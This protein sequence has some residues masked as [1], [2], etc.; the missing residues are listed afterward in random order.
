MRILLIEDEARISRFVSKGLRENSFAV[1]V[2]AS[3][4]TALYQVSINDYDLIILDVMIPAPNG[5]EVCRRIRENK[6][7]VP[8][9]MLTARD[10]VEDRIKGLNLGADDYLTKPFDF[11]ELLARIRALLR[12]GNALLEAK[13]IIAD[14]EI[15]TQAQRVWRGDTEIILTTKEFALLEFLA[16]E[17][18][19]VV[20]REEIS[21]HVWD[22]NFDSF[23]NLIEVYINR[24]RR[25]IDL[26]EKIPLFHTRRG[27]GYVLQD[28]SK[29]KSDV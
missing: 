12:R 1:D 29:N 11:G 10:A 5:F 23:S 9:L 24:L 7:R 19:R 17:R 22:E 20:G 4:E 26:P 16:R 15:D 21:T 6:N 28:F 2:A 8:V 13:I 27:A 14:L 18:G 25:K 3:G